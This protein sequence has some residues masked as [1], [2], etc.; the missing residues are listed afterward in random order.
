MEACS[1]GPN[2]DVSRALCHAAGDAVLHRVLQQGVV[3]EAGITTV[4]TDWT[5]LL[6]DCKLLKRRHPAMVYGNG[7]QAISTE[8][9]PVRHELPHDWGALA[10]ELEDLYDGSIRGRRRPTSSAQDVGHTQKDGYTN[11]TS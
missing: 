5:Q 9:Y 4:P 7:G 3:Q 1:G 10:G 6:A 8:F 2:F 11:P